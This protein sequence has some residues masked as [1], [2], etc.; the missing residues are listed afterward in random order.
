MGRGGMKCGMGR[1]AA[2][3]TPLTIAGMCIGFCAHSCY[4]QLAPT[5][6][7]DG[8][9]IRRAKQY[10]RLETELLSH[11]SADPM[12]GLLVFGS[13]AESCMSCIGLYLFSG[14]AGAPHCHLL[15][16]RLWSYDVLR[17]RPLNGKLTRQAP[18]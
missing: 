5:W 10:Y 6:R 11:S 15:H 17:S 8:V 3:L 7:Q 18:T 9:V 4:S 14:G 1:S 2:P 16:G 13:A 12:A